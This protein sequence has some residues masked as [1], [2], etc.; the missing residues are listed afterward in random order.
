MDAQGERQ[1]KLEG[2]R[3]TEGR[4][5]RNRFCLSPEGMRGW[6]SD[7]G[8]QGDARLPERNPWRKSEGYPNPARSGPSRH[9]INGYAEAAAKLED[10]SSLGF[11]QDEYPVTLVRG[12][13][14][15]VAENAAYK[16]TGHGAL[17]I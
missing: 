10:L 3:P 12:E 7:E 6:P 4:A 14:E 2:P 11:W 8:G 9:T 16:A 17:K 5:W 13:V 1:T 15:T